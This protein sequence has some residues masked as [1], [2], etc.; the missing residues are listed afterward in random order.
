MKTIDIK[1]DIV[2]SGDWLEKEIDR[3]QK[4][5]HIDLYD[6][7]KCNAQLHLLK[8]IKQRSAALSKVCEVAWNNGHDHNNFPSPQTEIDSFLNSKI[9]IE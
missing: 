9:E 5:V 1:N 3:L 7:F 8:H 4:R 6:E 2:V